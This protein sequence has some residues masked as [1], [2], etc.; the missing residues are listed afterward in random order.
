MITKRYI[1]SR[2]TFFDEDDMSNWGIEII[3]NMYCID[4][5]NDEAEIMEIILWY[6]RWALGSFRMLF[7]LAVDEKLRVEGATFFQFKDSDNL[8]YFLS[9]NPSPH[10]AHEVWN[11]LINK[12]CHYEAN[13]RR[14]VQRKTE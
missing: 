13:Y 10:I 7:E 6:Q 12:Y 5:G 4:P 8:E 14:S 2:K 3:W 9:A 1:L 11:D